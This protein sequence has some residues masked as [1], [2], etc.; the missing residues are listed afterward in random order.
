LAGDWN[1]DGIDT[2]AVFD[3]ENLRYFLRN[4]N[5]GGFGEIVFEFGETGAVP[6]AGDWDGM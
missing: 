2:I 6:L 5:T 4:S 3:P 1:G